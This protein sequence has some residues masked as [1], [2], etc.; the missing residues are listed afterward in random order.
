VGGGV[1]L[2][3]HGKYRVA[4]ENTGNNIHINTIP[5]II[6]VFAMPETGI[7]FFPDVGGTYFLSRLDLKHGCLGKYL[8]LTGT[9]LKGIDTVYLNSFK[10]YN[11]N[12]LFFKLKRC[13]CSNSLCSIQ[14]F[15]RLGN[16]F[17]STR[18]KRTSFCGSCWERD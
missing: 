14:S 16:R 1:G 10:H 4:T 7:G 13:R 12:I 18:R 5:E 17:T 6:R 3:V 8:G 15:R 11:F 2:S 9:I